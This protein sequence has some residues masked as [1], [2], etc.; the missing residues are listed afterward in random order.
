MSKKEY[1]HHNVRKIGLNDEE[2]TFQC[3]Y[4]SRKFESVFELE[5]HEKHV[6]IRYKCKKCDYLSFG[7]RDLQDHTDI[8]H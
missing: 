4:C 2:K 3:D 8:L 1:F 7:K 6:H 5:N